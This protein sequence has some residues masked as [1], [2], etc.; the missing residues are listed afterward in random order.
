MDYTLSRLMTFAVNDPNKMPDI[1]TAY[2]FMD[3]ERADSK[4]QEEIPDWK[5]DRL[6]FMKQAERI[7]NYRNSKK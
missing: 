7:K 3:D 1:K 6:E 4:P 2:G 5:K